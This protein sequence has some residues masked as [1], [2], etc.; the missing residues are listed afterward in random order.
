MCA[1]SAGF[2]PEDDD[3]NSATIKVTNIHP[4]PLTDWSTEY[5]ATQHT[6]ALIW[7]LLGGSLF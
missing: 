5:E 7:Q 4:I 3:L 1:Q 6:R 2:I